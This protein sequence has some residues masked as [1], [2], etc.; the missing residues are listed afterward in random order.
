QLE[1]A[2]LAAELPDDVARVPVDLVGGPGVAGVDEQVAVGV[3]VDRVDVE[4]VPGGRGCRGKGL[5]AVAVRHAAVAPPREGAPPGGDVV[6]R[7]HPVDR[8][9]VGGPADGGQVGS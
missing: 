3:D 2:V 8:G 7:D 6:P 4:P 1:A 9:R 5:F